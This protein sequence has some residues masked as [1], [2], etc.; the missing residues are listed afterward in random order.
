M[1]LED[2]LLE[3]SSIFQK[4]QSTISVAVRMAQFVLESGAGESGLYKKSYNG[5]GIKA[6]APWVGD[7]VLHESM[8]ADGKLHASYFRK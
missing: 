1:K 6:S 8:E 7:K 2:R 5:F 4:Y 3:V